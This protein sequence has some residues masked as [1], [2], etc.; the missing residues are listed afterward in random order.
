MSDT[1]YDWR[2]FLRKW[3]EELIAAGESVEPLPEEVIKSGWLGYPGATSEAIQEAED[4]LGLALPPSYRAFLMV[5]NGW[6][7]T[8]PFIWT[9]WST[10]EIDW[11]AVQHQED[12][13]DAY[14]EGL[15]TDW[16]VPDEQYF[17]YGPGQNEWSVRLEYLQCALQ[18]S[19]VGDAAVYLLNPAVV[20]PDGEWEAWFDS[21]WGGVKR[22]RSFWEL[23]QA[24][25][26]S[27]LAL[28]E[29]GGPS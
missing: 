14:A 2:P 20:T 25:Y 4:R 24:E 8:T 1:I 29:Q 13:I 28:R 16:V 22:Y 9:V 5:S 15:G 10:E 21:S 18:I 3:S 26:A 23:M 7:Q 19:D 11:L 12:W 17:V 27:F 6:R